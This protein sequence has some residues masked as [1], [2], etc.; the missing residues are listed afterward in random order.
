MGIAGPKC[1]ALAFLQNFTG[2][3][4]LFPHAHIL[5]PDGVF[6]ETDGG[7]EFAGLPPPTDE[8]VERVLK[9]TAQRVRKTAEDMFPEGLPWPE[10]A[11][12]AL[13]QASVQ[14]RLLLGDAEMAPS[15]KGRRCVAWEG[16]SLHANTQ[17]RE[18]DRQGLERLLRYGARGPLVQERL[19]RQEDGRLVYRLKRPLMGGAD[20]LVMT[21]LQ[22]AKRLAALVGKP[23]VHLTRCFGLFASHHA[24][25]E[26]VVEMER[27]G[28][29]AETPME[30]PAEGTTPA[31][32]PTGIPGG[33]VKNVVTLAMAALGA[34]TNA[35][36]NTNSPAQMPK[37]PRLDWRGLLMRV[38]RLDVLVCT[39]CGGPRR[40]LAV[41]HDAQVVGQIRGHR[42]K[43]SGLV[44]ARMAQGPPQLALPL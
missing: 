26:A 28:L 32:S 30:E 11:C 12:Q 25:R 29:E 5:V 42:E 7:L 21:P 18:N 36:E 41:I 43:Q 39:R 9:R 15:P 16:Y 37:R 6:L 19:S 23:R 4:L 24:R 31:P 40:V 1:A 8:E 38:F 27:E 35:D 10:E 13:A 20:T 17:V 22:L 44:P 33:F 34:M 3:L 2:A 14:T